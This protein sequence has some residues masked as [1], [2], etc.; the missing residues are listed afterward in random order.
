MDV[1]KEREKICRFI[2]AGLFSLSLVLLVGCVVRYLPKAIATCKAVS[3]EGKF[4]IDCVACEDKKVALSFEVKGTDKDVEKILSILENKNIKATFFVSGDWVKQ[5]PEEIQV[6]SKS[7]CDLGNNGENHM[8]MSHMSSGDC[9]EEV[10]GLHKKI[11][12]LTGMEMKLFRAPYGD[13]SETLI[14]SLNSLGYYPIG[15]NIDSL[16]WK[17]YGTNSIINEICNN[18]ELKKGSIIKLHTG[19]KFT[20]KALDTVIETLQKKGYQLVRISDIVLSENYI[21]DSNGCQ[22]S[23]NEK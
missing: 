9:M 2:K 8:R 17:D 16:D 1:E 23:K 22:A 14:H 15:G 13:F 6:I 12:E 10:I 19:T 18:E 20:D 3:E 5:Y 21:I 11:R 4:P 7:G